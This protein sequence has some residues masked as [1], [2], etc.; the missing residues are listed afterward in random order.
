MKVLLDTHAFLWYVLADPSMSSAAT[1]VISDSGNDVLVSPASFWET[2]I[3]VSLGKYTLTVPFEVFWREGIDGNGF[4]TLNVDIRHAAVVAELPFHHRDPF[5]RLLV[6]QAM[7]EGVPL[8]SAD[9]P[10][11]AYPIRRIW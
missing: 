9:E 7:V 10:L 1:A 4:D 2:A 6:A 5:D 11:D 8:V 3:K